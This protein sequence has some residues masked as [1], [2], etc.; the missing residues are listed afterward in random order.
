LIKS[1]HIV[2]GSLCECKML[3]DQNCCILLYDLS[4]FG[5]ALGVSKWLCK[6]HR[7]KTS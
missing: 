4:V 3:R 7:H 6:I 1:K 5:R 2:C